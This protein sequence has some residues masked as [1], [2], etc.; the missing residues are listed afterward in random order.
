MKAAKKKEDATKVYHVVKRDD[1]K[2]SVKFATGEKAIKLF[3]TKEEAMAYT[4]KMA[5]NQDGTVLVHASKGK[6][7]GKIRSR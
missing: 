1:G 2:W 6:F 4:K 7:K 3:S 5:D